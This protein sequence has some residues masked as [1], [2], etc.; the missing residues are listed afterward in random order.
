MTLADYQVSIG[1]LLSTGM[2]NAVRRVCCSISWHIADVATSSVAGDRVEHWE[3]RR[4]HRL[5][6]QIYFRAIILPYTNKVVAIVI[7]SSIGL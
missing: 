7:I 1:F 2:T 4:A 6:G 5:I 3:G